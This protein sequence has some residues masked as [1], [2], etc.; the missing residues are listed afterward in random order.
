MNGL[1]GYGVSSAEVHFTP[2]RCCRHQS[3]SDLLR[4][5]S[6]ISSNS[7][8]IGGHNFSCQIPQADGVIQG[9]GRFWKEHRSF[10]RGG[11]EEVPEDRRSGI[12]RGAF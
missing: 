2:R 12:L 6:N 1:V 4:I 9:I 10:G 8:H 3:T 7:W 5:V 11:M